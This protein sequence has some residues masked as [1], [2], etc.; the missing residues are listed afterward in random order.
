MK[1][2]FL[3]L[4]IMLSCIS[5]SQSRIDPVRLFDKTTLSYYLNP[6]N[7]FIRGWNWG[8]MGKK[9]D[10]ALNTKYYHG[11]PTT[12]LLNNTFFRISK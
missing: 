11:I 2:I 6:N 5:Y 9:I 4:I 10:E 12:E 3:M 7:E 1:K 8:T